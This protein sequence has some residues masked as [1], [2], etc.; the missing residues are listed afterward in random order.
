MYRLNLSELTD[1]PE[2]VV[3]LSITS[4]LRLPKSRDSPEGF[5]LMYADNTRYCSESASSGF[6]RRAS[7]NC[8][9]PTAFVNK[10][11]M[12]KG[13]SRLMAV[14]S[15]LKTATRSSAL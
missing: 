14:D 4:P 2:N 3:R 10:S 1:C 9:P 7:R 8:A 15:P 12:N 13:K 11:V 5:G 6:G